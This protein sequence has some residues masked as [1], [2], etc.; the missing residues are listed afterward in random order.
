[1]AAILC[2]LCYVLFVVNIVLPVFFNT[3]LVKNVPRK[4]SKRAG[5]KHL[6]ATKRTP[7]TLLPKHLT[8]KKLLQ[9]LMSFLQQNTD[10]VGLQ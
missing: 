6:L 4:R 5:P 10:F 2:S 8:H 3:A 1:M 9:Q 7:R